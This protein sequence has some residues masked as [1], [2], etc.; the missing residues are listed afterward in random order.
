MD[1]RNRYKIMGNFE[2]EWICRLAAALITGCIMGYERHVKAKEAGITTH[3]ILAS[4]SCLLMIIS[5]EAFPFADKFDAAR[6]AAQVVSGIGFLGAGVIFVRHDMLQGLTTAAGI[7]STAA[8][9]LAYGA[10]MYLL[11]AIAG[12]MLLGTEVVFDLSVFSDTRINASFRIIMDR[13]GNTDD[14]IECFH[15][16]GWHNTALHI[17]ASEE[18]WLINT[19]SYTQKTFSPYA[20]EEKL[21]ALPCVR[22]VYLQ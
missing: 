22:S 4:A 15:S 3:A 9:G 2:F 19:E 10:G 14:V 13:E 11:A 17:R 1:G 7:F 20:L 21:K 6:V 16:V 12:V 8:I 5:Q 18:G